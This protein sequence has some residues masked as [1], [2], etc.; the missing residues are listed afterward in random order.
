MASGRLGIPGSSTVLDVGCGTG[1]PVACALTAVGH[2]VTGIDISDVPRGLDA[3]CSERGF[4]SSSGRGQPL[5]DLGRPDHLRQRSA[6]VPQGP[7]LYLPTVR[8]HP[9]ES[10]ESELSPPG[11]RCPRN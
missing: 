2:R 5:A 6:F 8:R 3:L 1:V 9:I 10:F 11:S 7:D 4:P